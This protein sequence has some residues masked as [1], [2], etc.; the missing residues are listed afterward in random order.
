MNSKSGN[1]FSASASVFE[2]LSDVD[3]KF[4]KFVD[5]ECDAINGEVKKWFKK[6]AVCRST[7]FQACAAPTPTVRL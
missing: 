2:V 3:V 1:A 4:S 6:L 5:K 7:S